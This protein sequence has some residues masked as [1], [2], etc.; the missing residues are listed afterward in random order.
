MIGFSQGGCAAAFVASLLEPS[1]P[2]AFRAHQEKLPSALPY[3]ESFVR[4]KKSIEQGELKFAVSFSGFYA[5]SELYSAFY[6]PKIQTKMLH[7]IGSLDSVVEEKRST[8]LVKACV[9]TDNVLYHPG[10]HFVPIGKEVTG[11]L[12]GFI[13]EC[14]AEKQQEESVEDME[15]PF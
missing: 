4:L 2:K 12:A 1:R 13:R 14:C 6:E 15:V 8:A 10:G 5:P 9:D 7:V 3:P 11:V